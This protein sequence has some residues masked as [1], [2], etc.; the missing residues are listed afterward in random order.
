MKLVRMQICR[1]LLMLQSSRCSTASVYPT[2]VVDPN[3]T[4]VS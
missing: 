3:L 4:R 1:G 2:M